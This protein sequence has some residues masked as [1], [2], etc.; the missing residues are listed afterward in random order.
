MLNQ[1]QVEQ[2]E[3]ESEDSNLIEW[4]DFIP[5]CGCSR[6]EAV[7]RNLTNVERVMYGLPELAPG[8]KHKRSNII[9]ADHLEYY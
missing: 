6:C 3:I 7:K 1:K 8:Q 5:H 9:H 4:T 2:E